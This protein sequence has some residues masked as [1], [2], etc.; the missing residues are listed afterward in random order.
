MGQFLQNVVAIINL[1]LGCVAFEKIL[2]ERNTLHMCFASVCVCVCANE[3]KMHSTR[4]DQDLHISIVDQCVLK[5]D[6]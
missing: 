4:Q 5:M 2:L 6:N 3:C 1:G